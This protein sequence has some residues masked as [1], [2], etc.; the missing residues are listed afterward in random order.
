[1]VPWHQ[2]QFEHENKEQINN[3]FANNNTM[4]LQFRVS[5]FLSYE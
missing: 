5:N 3:T 4:A 2:A 1:M